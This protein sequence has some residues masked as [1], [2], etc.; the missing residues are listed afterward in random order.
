[1]LIIDGDPVNLVL[2]TVKLQ[3]TKI[4]ILSDTKSYEDNKSKILL[5]H[6]EACLYKIP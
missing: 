1:M 5:I 4:I 3:T 6:K 2:I